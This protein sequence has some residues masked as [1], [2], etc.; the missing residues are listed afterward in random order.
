MAMTEGIRGEQTRSKAHTGGSIQYLPSTFTLSTC[1]KGAR[2]SAVFFLVW[3]IFPAC[4]VPA[5]CTQAPM[6]SPK[7]DCARSS[8]AATSASEVMSAPQPTTEGPSSLASAEAA[9]PLRSATMT[10]APFLARRRTTPAPRPDAPP[11][12]RATREGTLIGAV[13]IARALS[14]GP[15]VPR[16]PAYNM[17]MH[18][19]VR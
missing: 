10:L 18:M 8:A 12:T 9:S 15:S 16:Q 13:M 6:T 1:S 3:T 14:E 5:V 2:S 19:Y 11:E 7:L 4:K 17:Y